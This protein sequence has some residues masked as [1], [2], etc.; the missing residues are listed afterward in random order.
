MQIGGEW[1][2]TDRLGS[3]VRKGT[4][5]Y[6]Y[7]PYGQEIG[8]ATAND[9]TKFA[10]YTRDSLSG[11][12]YALNRYYKPE[13]GRFTSPDPYQASGGPADP[14]SWNR[15]A[16]VGGDPVN[17]NDSSGLLHYPVWS[18]GKE[19]VVLY[20]LLLGVSR[21]PLD[22]PML[23]PEAEQEATPALFETIAFKDIDGSADASKALGVEDCYK[24][25]GFSSA[26]A[27][28]TRLEQAKYRTG[29][30]GPTTVD[31][32]GAISGL[33][34][35]TTG[36]V[37]DLNSTGGIFFAPQAVQ[38]TTT[39]GTTQTV[40]LLSRFESYFLLKPES[41]SGSLYRAVTLLHELGHIN[42]AFKDDSGDPQLSM[43]Y[44]KQI[45]QSCFKAL[46]K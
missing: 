7:A 27:A 17:Y 12:D 42:N 23:D 37:V 11:L 31:S 35:R 9:T 13:W 30:L 14:G 36:G 4:T 45:F 41:L 18:G 38:A 34:A 33:P 15:Y 25:L 24:L 44:T 21:M 5:N 46:V 3:V 40:N 10:T 2:A 19:S 20:Y 29:D 39:S 28:I 26:D 43:G 1:V 32:D 16:Y 8:G 22:L 6:K